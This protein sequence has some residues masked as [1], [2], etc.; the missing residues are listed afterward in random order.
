MTVTTWPYGTDADQHD[1][2]TVLRIPVTGSQPT[3]RYIAAFDRDSAVRPT[4][5]EARMIASH[6][7]AYK[8]YFFGDSWFRQQT[9]KMPFDIGAA[10]VVFHKWGLG[11]W[12]SRLATWQ[13]GRWSPRGPLVQVLDRANSV[14]VGQ[15]SLHWLDWKAARPDIFPPHSKE[16]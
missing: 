13:A 7:D 1:P 16:I 2:L 15:P 3:R 14:L 6:I 10:T 5:N 12:S 11:D 9:D 8:D 4:D